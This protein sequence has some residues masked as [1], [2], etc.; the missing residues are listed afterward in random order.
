[1]FPVNDTVNAN[2]GRKNCSCSG[3]FAWSDIQ[4]NQGHVPHKIGKRGSEQ[5]NIRKLLNKYLHIISVLDEK[6][7][8]DDQQCQL[9]H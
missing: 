2:N 6:N 1:M 3:T 5:G 7:V 9:K 4:G 8:Q